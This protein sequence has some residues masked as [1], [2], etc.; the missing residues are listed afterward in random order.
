M[1]EQCQQHTGVTA[2]VNNIKSWQ[3][4]HE[5]VVHTKIDKD[6][7]DLSKRLPLWATLF[8]SFLVGLASAMGTAL[9]KG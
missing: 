6:M 1:G 4:N 8:I 3:H 7:E 9:I 5:G 2:E